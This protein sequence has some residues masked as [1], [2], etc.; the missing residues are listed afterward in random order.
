MK[1][2]KS[3]SRGNNTNQLAS[4]EKLIFEI[5]WLKTSEAAEYLRTS[6]AQI[7]NWVYQGKIKAHKLFDRSLRFK[8]SDLDFLLKE[9]DQEWV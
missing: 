8:K 7:R 5:S 3:F 9:G 6:P 1:E 4:S 2:M